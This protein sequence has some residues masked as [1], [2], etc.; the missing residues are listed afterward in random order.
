MHELSILQKRTQ[1]VKR[2]MLNDLSPGHFLLLYALRLLVP[3]S[4]S[5]R[6]HPTPHIQPSTS[7]ERFDIDWGGGGCCYI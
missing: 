7:G 5:P 6:Y 3:K 4:L 2:V 1:F